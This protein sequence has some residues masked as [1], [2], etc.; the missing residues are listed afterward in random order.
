MI[1]FARY[2]D[3]ACPRRLTDLPRDRRSASIR[4]VTARCTCPLDAPSP[5]QLAS[6]QGQT[7]PHP[8]FPMP[9]RPTRHLKYA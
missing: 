6:G 3:R 2:P 4:R 9:P 7:A 5:S 8:S 1:H